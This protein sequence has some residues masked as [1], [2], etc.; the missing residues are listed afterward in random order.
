MALINVLVI[1]VVAIAKIKM[2]IIII[3]MRRVK[4]IYEE[5]YIDNVVNKID[6]LLIK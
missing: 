5:D 3:I 4:R 2:D 1:I 6:D